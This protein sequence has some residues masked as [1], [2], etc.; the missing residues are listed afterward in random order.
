MTAPPTRRPESVLGPGHAPRWAPLRHLLLAGVL[1]VL[2]TVTALPLVVGA[3][4]GGLVTLSVVLAVVIAV[5]SALA[6][7][8]DRIAGPGAY[9][10]FRYEGSTER[11]V[12]LGTL[13]SLVVLAVVWLGLQLDVDATLPDEA[14]YLTAALPF[15][16]V[17][18]L[19][20]PGWWRRIGVLVVA[21]CAVL[22]VVHA[23]DLLEA[24]RPGAAAA[25]PPPAP[26]QPAGP[27]T[28]AGRADLA[29]L[30][31]RP[32]V[33]DDVPDHHLFVLSGGELG[34]MA[35]RYEP[36]EAV[37]WGLM[38]TALPAEAVPGGDPCAAPALPTPIGVLTLS[39]CAL[40]D[41]GVWLRTSDQVVSGSIQG[42]RDVVAQR[43]GQWVAVSAGPDLDVELLRD[44]LEQTAPLTD[45]ALDDWL[46]SH[47]Y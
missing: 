29:G 2:A 28:L 4:F 22:A 9:Q 13:G 30:S 10:R 43:D 46:D 16:L 12:A 36:D 27:T 11:G 42:G 39:E 19:Q 26:P 37:S 24:A 34:G 5:V 31:E 8:L 38:V 33:A 41:E 40:L 17:A 32:W 15:P 1:G 47:G 35:A 18:A 6:V 3:L 25:P 21:G 45:E 7:A 20:W 44:T 14:L 23:E